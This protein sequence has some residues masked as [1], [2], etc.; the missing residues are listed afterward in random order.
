MLYRQ[1]SILNPPMLVLTTAKNLIEPQNPHGKQQADDN[2]SVGCHTNLTSAQKRERCDHCIHA[3]CR[4][5]L[6][7][8]GRGQEKHVAEEHSDR[9]V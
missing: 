6:K 8:H 2:Q 1:V 3:G 7:T 4:F 9:K 5:M